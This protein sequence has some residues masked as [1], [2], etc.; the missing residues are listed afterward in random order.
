MRRLLPEPADDIAVADAYASPLGRRPDR[1]WVGL[2]MVASID[3]STVVGG[4]SAGLSS[5]T[6]A[7]VVFQLRAIADV[8]VVGAGTV[9][10]EGYGP[11]RKPGQRIGVVTR[12]GDVDLS[13]A[14][15]TS[16]AGFVIT[17]EDATFDTAGID[18]VRAGTGAV[19]FVAAVARLRLLDPACGVVQAEGGATLNGALLDAD[20]I[21]E[22]NVTTSP[23]AVGGTGP[24]LAAGAGNHQHRFDLAQLAI[25]D[26]SFVYA[27]WLRRRG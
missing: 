25:D 26:Q 11:P 1:P 12:S 17:T 3:G 20:V 19:D 7:A 16:G 23:A 8:I 22:I 5:P 14:L 21:D 4:N 10:D 24:R 18:V 13:S 6:D 2:C 27:R 15:F 9:R